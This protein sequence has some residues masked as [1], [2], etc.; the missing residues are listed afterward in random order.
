MREDAPIQFAPSTALFNRAGLI[1]HDDGDF[2][3]TSQREGMYWLGV[4][5]RRNQLKR[6]WTDTPPRILSFDDVLKKLEPNGDGMFVRAP[7]KD[8][9]GRDTDGHVNHG[10]TRDQLVPMIAAMAAWGKSAEL[11]R[12]WNAL[13]ED[14]LG[15]HDFQGRWFDHLSGEEFFVRDPCVPGTAKFTECDSKREVGLLR[16][17]GDPLPPTAYN[18]FVRA[19]VKT[20]ARFAL[21]RSLLTAD[22]FLAGDAN[23]K[24]G[25]DLLRNQ[26]TGDIK[27]EQSSPDPLDCVDQDMNTTVMLWLSR[28]RRPT[29]V[30]EAAIASYRSRAH[31]N[32]SNVDAFCAAYGPLVVYKS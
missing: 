1:M 14:I 20:T 17:T 11:Q 31:S 19:G 5:I 2:G 15:K 13:P 28:F 32:G 4:W 6:P 21:T 9:F 16:F 30:S 22:G 25:V 7:G 26:A 8:P 18:M 29:P 24:A 27:C 3:D 12:L 10:M 23:L